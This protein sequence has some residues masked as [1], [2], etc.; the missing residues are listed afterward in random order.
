MQDMP[1]VDA[2]LRRRWVILL[3]LSAVMY[4]ASATA[5]A[6]DN[7]WQFFAWGSQVL[8]GAHQAFVRS[9]LRIAGDLPG[10]LHLYASYPFLQIG[11][12][13]LLAAKVLRLGPRDGL[14]VAGA[15]TQA[16]GLVAV[17]ATERAFA[18]LG[19]GRQALLLL[20]GGLALLVWTSLAHVTHLDDALALAAIAIAVWALA[21]GHFTSMGALLGLAAASKPW[22]VAALALTLRPPDLR[23]RLASSCTAVVVVLMFWGPFLLVDHD[24]TRLG[25][26]HLAVS[27]NSPLRALGVVAVGHPMTLRVAQFALAFLV[28]AAIVRTRHWELALVAGFGCRLLL[29]PAGYAYYSASMAIAALIAD[30]GFRRMPVPMFTLLAA[31]GW[32]AA[33]L[34]SP[35]ATA[36]IR[37]LDYVAIGSLASVL[38]FR[39]RVSAPSQTRATPPVASEL[40]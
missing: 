35:T 13:G 9:G 5:V 17:W 10:G 6:G 36:W 1:L 23:Q 39:A 34:P 32:G 31:V 16:L 14:Y 38:A 27:S 22:A 40:T 7:D 24:T 4:V 30:V 11:P 26:V 37:L 3:A 15:A 8:F 21:T 12:L 20:G 25:D 28:V 2:L 19:R 18:P 29:E 33:D